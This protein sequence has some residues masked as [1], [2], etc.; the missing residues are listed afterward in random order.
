MDLA[1]NLPS[2]SNF[3][4]PEAIQGGGV[5]GLSVVTHNLWSV[6]VISAG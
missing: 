4:D 1:L 6:S 3:F 5:A 2:S